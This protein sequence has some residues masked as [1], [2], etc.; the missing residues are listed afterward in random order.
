MRGFRGI[1]LTIAAV[2]LAATAAAQEMRVPQHAVAGF[3][4]QKR[5][6]GAPYGQVRRRPHVTHFTNRTAAHQFGHEDDVTVLSME[7]QPVAVFT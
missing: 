3:G 2:T 1:V 5:S 7:L 4:R 6:T